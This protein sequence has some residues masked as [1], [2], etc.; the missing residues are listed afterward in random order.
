M[1]LLSVVK[2]SRL[3]TWSLEW[4]AIITK[5][6]ALLI[7]S[8][9]IGVLVRHIIQ[10]LISVPYCQL[11]EI[12]IRSGWSLQIEQP[13]I[14]FR[15]TQSLSEKSN[16]GR[17][18]LAFGVPVIHALSASINPCWDSITFTQRKKPSSTSCRNLVIF[19]PKDLSAS[20]VM[21]Q[22]RR[23]SII[24]KRALSEQSLRLHGILRCTRI[25]LL[26]LLTRQMRVNGLT[27]V[28]TPMIELTW[29]VC[30][31][32]KKSRLFMCSR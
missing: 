11:F 29:L 1:R 4:L 19:R 13:V 10:R 2:F 3:Q 30:I 20:L 5:C 9:M 14:I 15:L 28:I 25:L 21:V 8:R 23:L 24:A 32:T 26:P 17:E 22:M 7:L 12:A 27:T 16:T 31:I 6:C 18:W